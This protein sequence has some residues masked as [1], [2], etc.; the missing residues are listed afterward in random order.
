M[1]NNSMLSNSFLYDFFFK[2]SLPFTKFK[3][4]FFI[5]SATNKAAADF[6]T[7]DFM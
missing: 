5:L 4:F 7:S 3:I 2:Y 6:L 1:M